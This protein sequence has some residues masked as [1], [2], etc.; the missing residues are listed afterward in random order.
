M[1]T[2]LSG[3]RSNDWRIAATAEIMRHAMPNRVDSVT[4]KI[5]ASAAEIY[6]AMLHPDALEFWLV[7]DGIQARVVAFSPRPGGHYRL[8]METGGER[9]E[10]EIWS[11]AKHMEA[12][13]LDLVPGKCIVQAVEF[14]TYDPR[15][16]GAMRL[17]WLLSAVADGTKVTIRA[18][19]APDGLSAESHEAEMTAS[20]AKLDHYVTGLQERQV[21]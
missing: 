3:T 1:F 6:D 16:Q 13:Y 11:S 15:F 21:A 18:E 8:Q 9:D 14:A 10:A 20:L 7:P 4:R 17:S 2:E 12:R 5:G 19:N